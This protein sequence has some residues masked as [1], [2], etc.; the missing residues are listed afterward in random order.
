MRPI[1]APFSTL[2]ILIDADSIH[3]EWSYFTRSE[4][5]Q[6]ALQAKGYS[7]FIFHFKISVEAV[8]LGGSSLV[9]CLISN[10]IGAAIASEN[11]KSKTRISR[12]FD[13]GVG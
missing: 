5:S 11:F 1:C 2:S 3:P 9:M 7:P 8:L 13:R 12:G 6:C 10:S 4:I